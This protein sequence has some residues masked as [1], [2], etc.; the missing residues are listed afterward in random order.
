[1]NID[2]VNDRSDWEK[3]FLTPAIQSQNVDLV[4]DELGHQG[5]TSIFTLPLFNEDY[6]RQL[7]DKCETYGRWGEREWAAYPTNDIWLEDIG[8]QEIYED[9][10]LRPHVYPVI[11]KAWSLGPPWETQTVEAQNFVAK[12]DTEGQFHLDLHHD[13]SLV[14]VV[15]SLNDEFEGGGT[16]FYRQKMLVTPKKGEAIFHPGNITHRHGA[17]PVTKGARYSLVSFIRPM[18]EE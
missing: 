8:M 3:S 6:C 5:H 16:Y 17:R 2:N 18:F 12:Y 4:L 10:V 1:M 11:A 15:V 7:I 9:A 14:T 13:D